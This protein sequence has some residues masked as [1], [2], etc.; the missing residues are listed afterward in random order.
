MID[1]QFTADPRTG[2]WSWV[3]LGGYIDSPER[4]GL[5]ARIYEGLAGDWPKA[6]QNALDALGFMKRLDQWDAG[7]ISSAIRMLGT[8]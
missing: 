5:R 1:L 4:G 6:S 8:P 3:I 2:I 7:E